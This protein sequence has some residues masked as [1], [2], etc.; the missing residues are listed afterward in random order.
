MHCLRLFFICLIFSSLQ[1]SLNAQALSFESQSTVLAKLGYSSLEKAKTAYDFFITSIAQKKFTSD[2]YKKCS[3]LYKK[4]LCQFLRDYHAKNSKKKSGSGRAYSKKHRI[5]L[6]NTQLIQKENYTQLLRRFPDKKESD[7]NLY[8]TQALKTKSCPRNFSLVL[9][10]EFEDFSEKAGTRKQIEKLYDHGLSCVKKTDEWSEFTHLRAGNFAK[11]RNDL[12]GAIKL[13]KKALQANRKREDYRAL[14]M[15]RKIYMTQNKTE[16]AEKIS[17]QIMQQFPRSWYAIHAYKDKNQDIF[18]IYSSRASIS[19]S[20]QSPNPILDYM[21]YWM[22]FAFHV[23]TVFERKKKLATKFI[24]LFNKDTDL[25]YT[26]H[27]ARRFDINSFYLHQ[28][29][30]LTRVFSKNPTKINRD[31]LTLLH[32]YPHEKAFSSLSPEI[33]T[34]IILG[35]SRQESSFD[36]NARSRANARGLMQILPSTAKRVDPTR[37]KHL[38]NPLNNIKIGYSFLNSL[39]ERYEGSIEKALGAYNAGP[40][41]MDKWQKMFSWVNDFESF[42][43]LIP[44]RE[45]RDYVPSILRNAYWY[46][47][48]YPEK[49]NKNKKDYKSAFLLRRHFPVMSNRMPSSLR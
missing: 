5:Q 12:D 29:S 47:R 45:T 24:R 48:L 13:Y 43:D 14:H 31:V 36:K 18:S 15:L 38:Y 27:M 46:H 9:A 34:A 35:L 11:L 16:K 2:E 28:I 40:H 3:K 39:I 23:D 33:D 22:K 17:Q 30:I 20:Y 1:F 6:S 44:Y 42:L 25:G 8:Y 41:K 4:N 7:L 19:D 37:Y 21:G 49:L 10:Y 32:P 26:L